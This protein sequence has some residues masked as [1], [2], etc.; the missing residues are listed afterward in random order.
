MIIYTK[1]HKDRRKI[2]DFLLIAKFELGIFF[3]FTLFIPFCC[4]LQHTFFS[5]YKFPHRKALNFWIYCSFFSSE[6]DDKILL[7]IF[8]ECEHL[9]YLTHTCFL[10]QLMLWANWRNDNKSKLKCIMCSVLNKDYCKVYDFKIFTGMT[11]SK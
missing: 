6:F 9:S 11:K 3:L 10:G 7:K 1:F 8:I 5:V 4:W 2:V